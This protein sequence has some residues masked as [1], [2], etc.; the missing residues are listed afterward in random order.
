MT[1]NNHR[2]LCRSLA[3]RRAVPPL[4]DLKF[5]VL[6]IDASAARK[7]VDVFPFALRLV[8]TGLGAILLVPAKPLP[9]SEDNS[10]TTLARDMRPERDGVNGK[11]RSWGQVTPK[12]PT[13]KLY[14]LNIITPDDAIA[15]IEHE[16]DKVVYVA[17]AARALGCEGEDN[18]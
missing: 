6:A 5:F 8:V 17:I 14:N 1:A 16:L 7:A 10:A 4:A 15:A 13:R 11:L 12:N 9:P 3:R 18:A 2:V